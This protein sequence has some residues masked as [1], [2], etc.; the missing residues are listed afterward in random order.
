M[1]IDGF[2]RRHTKRLIE[3]KAREGRAAGW[4]RLSYPPA[5]LAARIVARYHYYGEP[6]WR[7][8]QTIASRY[9]KMT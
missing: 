4:T 9:R 3:R 2:Y 7:S 8:V 5:E 6:S 1:V